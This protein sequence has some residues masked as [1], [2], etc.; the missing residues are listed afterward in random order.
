MNDLKLSLIFGT[1]SRVITFVNQVLSV[2]LTIAI[3]G[4]NE[5]T[6]FNVITAGIAWLITVGGCLLPS[7]VGDISRAKEDHNDIMISEKISS[8]LTVMVIFI[9]TVMIGYIFF[10]GVMDN[11]RNL[12][13]I[14][15]ILILLFSTAEN[16]RQGLGENY[17]NAIYNGCSNLLSLVIILGLAY[18][19]IKTNLQMV[20][21]VMFGS[22]TFFKLLNLLPLMRYFSL[23]HITFDSCKGML[24]KATGFVFLSVAY[25][26]NTAGLI[27][28]LNWLNY[29][30]LTEFIILQKI[31]LIVMG[32]VVM[33]RNPLWGVIAK[34]QYKGNSDLIIVNYRKVLR[35]YFYT[36]PLLVIIS[37]LCIPFFLKMWAGGIVISYPDIIAFSIYLVSIVFSYINS[38]LYYGLELF[39]K[40][41]RI[42][43]VESIVIYNMRII[44]CI[45]GA[46]V[47]YDFHSDDYHIFV[48]KLFYF[49]N[50]QENM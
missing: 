33:I 18:F 26:F 23:K 28:V 12:L 6:R 15:S 38:V 4:I 41:S 3:I 19:E 31:I 49:Q 22:I 16:V 5:F 45:N 48:Y 37:V 42:L 44:C 32:M 7:L 47:K 2:P 1:L 13:L 27:T 43:I 10:F 25:Y 40:I 21:I 8:A 30:K 14:F 29:T 11:E 24:D 46:K 17:K 36:A 35:V 50:Y 39:N 34:M 20:I 9:I